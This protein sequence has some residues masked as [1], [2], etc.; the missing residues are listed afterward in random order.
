M[1]ARFGQPALLVDEAPPVLVGSNGRSADKNASF[2][3]Y[4]IYAIWEGRFPTFRGDF[5]KPLK[6]KDPAAIALIGRC[7]RCCADFISSK[8]PRIKAKIEEI[9]EQ[10]AQEELEC[11]TC[12]ADPLALGNG[13]V[14][15]EDT[16]SGNGT[17]LDDGAVFGNTTVF[18]SGT[19]FGN[20]AVSSA[21]R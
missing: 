20:G 19:V 18:G 12:D 11:Q 8:C 14:F 13:T 17:V 2:T 21:S 10:Q 7:G 6:K 3:Q 9:H 1:C 5:Q 15:G 16:V 4:Q